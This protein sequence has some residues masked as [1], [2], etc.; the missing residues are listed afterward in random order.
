MNSNVNMA[1]NLNSRSLWSRFKRDVYRN[2]TLYI[3]L[4]PFLVF[5]LLFFYKPLMGLIVAFKDYN[6][7]WMK[8]S[9][10][11]WVGF[12]NFIKFF[13]GTYFF[14]LLKNTLTISI[15]SI[16][17]GFPAPI[18][19]ALLLNEIHNKAFKKTVQTISYLPHFVSSVVVCGIITSFLSPSTG[20][21]NVILRS[22]GFQEQY[23][24]I[25]PNYFVPIYT[26]MGLWQ[27]TG[28]SAIVYV[29]AITNIDSQLYDACVVDGGGR[30]RQ[31]FAVTIPGILPTVMVM[32]IMRIG[33][34][35]NVGY[36]TI[37]LLYQPA[38]YETADVIS[39]YV[40]RSGIVGGNYSMATTVGLFNSVIALILVST[41]NHLS[42]KYTEIGLW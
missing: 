41:A 1:L 11:N 31:L 19:L 21:V 39:T 42:K 20:V 37:I 35:L 30:W 38:T 6:N 40:Y 29:A 33:G 15:T 10:S 18:I 9:D 34:I 27:N 32:L 12:D 26:I 17:V 22:L 7:V 14:R 8:I 4:I 25:N 2:K 36:E 16:L 5:Y 23:F 28:F 3:M 13:Q 24:L